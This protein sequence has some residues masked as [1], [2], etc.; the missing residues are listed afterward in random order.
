MSKVIEARKNKLISVISS[1]S[2]EEL[3]MAF[4]EITDFKDNGILVEHS[5]L[6]RIARELHDKFKVPYDIRMVEDNILY[7]ATRRYYNSFMQL[8]KSQSSVS[9]TTPK[10]AYYVACSVGDTIY[11]VTSGHIEVAIVD[12]IILT[13]NN[14]LR[15]RARRYNAID[16]IYL[17]PNEYNKKWFID[18]EKAC[19]A[20]NTQ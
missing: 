2:D 1:L 6:A 18:Y 14:I 9:V 3:C 20:L 11:V 15:I 16:I 19:A 10:N 8:I 4:E 13:V 12:R 5:N 7:E 17:F